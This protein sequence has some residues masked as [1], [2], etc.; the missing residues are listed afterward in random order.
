MGQSQQGFQ[1]Q[2]KKTDLEAALLQLT[3]N[4]DKFMTETRTNFQN[5][6]AQIRNLE[7]QIGQLA[8]MYGGRQQGN[9]PS[10]TE[11]NPKEQCKAITLRSGKELETPS[12]GEKSKKNDQE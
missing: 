10:N 8:N 5:Q 4:T 3:N 1:P 12:R 11:V 7:A 2:E 9:L 6:A